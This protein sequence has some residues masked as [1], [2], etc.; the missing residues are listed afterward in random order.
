MDFYTIGS[1]AM[2]YYLSQ[3]IQGK[4]VLNYLDEP[5]RKLERMQ[6]M[7]FSNINFSRYLQPMENVIN[8]SKYPVD[9]LKANQ[10]RV[11]LQKYS[12]NNA[13]S[14]M[15]QNNSIYYNYVEN[16]ALNT[17]NTFSNYRQYN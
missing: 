8:P 15:A 14:K 10:V 6:G 7:S 1:L 3:R 13:V 12:P 5:Q 2:L 9:Q 11:S 4:T 16:N 17:A